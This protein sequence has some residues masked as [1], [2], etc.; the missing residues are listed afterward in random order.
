MKRLA[1]ITTVLAA[2]GCVSM[3]PRAQHI[4]LHSGVSTQLQNCKKLG[5]VTATA[6]GWGMLSMDDVR[7]QAANNLR[8]AAAAKWGD[9]VDSLAL[10]NTDTF[11]NS[12]S[13]SGIGYKCF[14]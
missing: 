14:D 8:D 4:Q 10:I 11:I 1:L 3:T 12:V 5:P 7:Q 2:S 6:S 13:A 9:T